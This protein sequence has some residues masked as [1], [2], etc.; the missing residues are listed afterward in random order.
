MVGNHS[1]AYG[2]DG[3]V[4]C[5][6]VDGL[7]TEGIR[8]ARGLGRGELMNTWVLSALSSHDIQDTFGYLHRRDAI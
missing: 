8:E 1:E 6:Y 5:Q 4:D 2:G 7:Q 3:C